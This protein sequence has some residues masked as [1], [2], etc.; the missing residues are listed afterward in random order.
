MSTLLPALFNW[1]PLTGG[2]CEPHSVFA[3]GHLTCVIRVALPQGRWSISSH[4]LE[5]PTGGHRSRRM[6]LRRNGTGY[7]EGLK[8]SGLPW[9][10]MI[11]VVKYEVVTTAV[12][13]TSGM[14]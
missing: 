3:L 12:V 1:Y 5:D 8:A 14:I 13:D 6:G 2:L 10:T 11:N 9:T 7:P 4:R